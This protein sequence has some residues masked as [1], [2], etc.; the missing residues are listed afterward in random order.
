MLNRSLWTK[1]TCAS[2][3]SLVPDFRAGAAPY[4][5]LHVRQ[6]WL[7]LAT[8]ARAACAM[9]YVASHLRLVS[10]PLTSRRRALCRIARA[11]RKNCDR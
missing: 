2:N 8:G 10:A 5:A 11:T 6:T 4:V 3:Y 9:R 1:V 7:S